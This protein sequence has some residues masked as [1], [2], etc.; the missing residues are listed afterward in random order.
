MRVAIAGDGDLESSLRARAH[1]AGVGDIGQFLGV[2]SHDVV[3]TFL[4]AA[5]LAVAPS[6]HDEAGNVDGLPNT[7]MEIM[8]SGAPLVATPV[9]GIGAVATDRVTARLVAE[10]DVRALATAIDRATARPVSGHAHGPAERVNS[11][12]AITAGPKWRG[13]RSRYPPMLSTIASLI[14][15]AYLP[16]AVIFRCQSPTRAKRAALLPKNVCS[17]RSSQRHRDDDLSR[18]CSRRWARFAARD[19]VVHAGL[20]TASPRCFPLGN[21]RLGTTAGRPNWTAALPAMLIAASASMYFAVPAAEYVLGGRDPG[22]YMNEG[23]QIAQ[24]RSLVTIDRVAS[25][26]PVP[27]RD[28][29][30]PPYFDPH[31]YSVRFMG[32]HLRDPNAG[33]VTG[34]FPQGYPVWIAIAYGLDGVTGARRVIAWWAILAVLTGSNFAASV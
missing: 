14:A 31:Y 24:G 20:A 28:L 26:V 10:G 23:I 16:G 19:R 7:V 12:A 22:V 11:C 8:A 2:V 30:F 6:V 17:G 1:S 5:D 33:T 9:G 29:F 3:P 21:L 15:I 34:Q 4:A 13:F 32:F 27:T 25:A 18:L